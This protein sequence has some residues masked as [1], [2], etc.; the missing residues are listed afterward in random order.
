MRKLVSLLVFAFLL[1]TA[2]YALPTITSFTPKIG[3]AGTVVTITG[4]NLSSPTAFTIGGVTAIVVSNTGTQ[5]VGIVM[6]GASTGIISVTNAGGTANS[7]NT[8]T[9]TATPFPSLQ[10]G[11]HLSGSDA[12]G[13]ANQGFSVAISADGNTAIVGGSDDNNYMGAAW[14]Y[15]RSGNVWA[16]QG[17]KLVG[18]GAVSPNVYQGLGVAISADGNTALVGGFKDNNNVGATW[19]FTRSG[20]TWNQQGN[21]LVGT[22]AVGAANQGAYVSLSADGNTA[23]IGG[24]TDNSLAGAAWVF[25]RSGSTWTQQGSKLIGTGSVGGS[26]QGAD[27]SLSADGNTAIIGGPGDNNNMGAA[28]IFT[29]SANI[30]T[31]QGAKLVGTG[32]VG[33]TVNQGWS[34]ALST[35][36]NTAIVG[37]EYDNYGQ[38]AAWIFTRSGNNWTQQGS[39]LIGLGA[40]GNGNQ[41]YDVALSADG[42]TAIIGADL[43]NGYQGAVYVFTRSGNVWSQ[44]G[45]KLVGTGNTGSAFQGTAV[46]VSADGNTMILGGNYDNTGIGA[47]WIFTAACSYNSWLG[48]VSDVWENPANWS[49]GSVPDGSMDVYIT[50]PTT[51][52]PVIRS[53]AVCRSLYAA[54]TASLV[55]ASGF[56]LTI[57][58]NTSIVTFEGG[59]M[60][61]TTA[62]SGGNITGDGGYPIT[63]RGVCW[64]T[65]PNPTIANSKTIDGAG[66]GAFNSSITG[67]TANTVYYARAYATNALGTFYGNQVTFTTNNRNRYDGIYRITGTLNDIVNPLITGNY[68]LQWDIITTGSATN[69]VYDNV[70]LGTLGHMIYNSGSPSY[71]G[72]FGLSLTFDPATDK[73]ISVDNYYG[74]PSPGNQ[75]C[76]VL[77]PTGTNTFN[78]ADHSIDIKYI[79]TQNGSD[80]T[81]FTEHW[82]YIGP[83]P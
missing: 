41:G 17:N 58:E 81:Y 46:S 74:C 57:K 47:A 40:I 36:G 11:G 30:W 37:G 14:I 34:V 78:A 44:Q 72:Q 49:C 5:L 60:T 52:S 67:L 2:C 76:A 75:R 6:P 32:A 27:V 3:P 26:Q 7:T 10:Q 28:W 16:Q 45:S 22:G 24:Y 4:T 13:N 54:P 25:T 1:N 50:V 65:S 83:R 66:K 43:D 18:T 8:F 70:N 42:N 53:L 51:Y 68:P 9:I 55:V 62:V 82:E 15:A 31:Q 33:T 20:T 80:R 63:A 79:M 35:D 77:D 71:Y 69:D 12:V 73:I 56:S 38:G 64:S 21:K 39:K 61:S 59:S 19:V 48:I 29:R 23:L